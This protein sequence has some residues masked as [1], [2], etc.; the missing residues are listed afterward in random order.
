MPEPGDLTR[1]VSGDWFTAPDAEQWVAQV[2]RHR[3]GLVTGSG[4]D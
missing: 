2:A 4:T 3:P 1:K